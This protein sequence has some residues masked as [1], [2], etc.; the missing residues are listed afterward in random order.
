MTMPIIT[1]TPAALAH[2]KE[3]LD[4]KEG[5]AVFRLS[6]KETGCTGLMYVPE[7][8]SESHDT[9]SVQKID[10]DL[11]MYIAQD[12]IS[13]IQGT[14]IDYITVSLGQKQL[15]Y[16]NPNA[17][18]LCGCGESFNLKNKNDD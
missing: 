16:D 15:S 9:D 11:M 1:L 17:D 2:I 7:I 4:S 5:A 14:T 18:S 13:S 6:I 12:A 3:M 10:S 8:I